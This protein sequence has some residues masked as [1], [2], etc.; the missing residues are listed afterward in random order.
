LLHAERA[1]VAFNRRASFAL[2]PTTLSLA[3]G[4]D[5]VSSQLADGQ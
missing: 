5:A 1:E 3:D 2:G 4:A